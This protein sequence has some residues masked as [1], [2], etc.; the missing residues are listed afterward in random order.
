M[1]SRYRGTPRLVVAP[2][3][4][5]AP[6]LRYVREAILFDFKGRAIAS[7]MIR[8]SAGSARINPAS[9][10]SSRERINPLQEAGSNRQRVD[11]IRPAPDIKPRADQ[12][13]RGRIEPAAD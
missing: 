4:V 7:D 13:A 1:P 6:C 10:G 5:H 9:T 2:F 12:A 3:E 8:L 11:P